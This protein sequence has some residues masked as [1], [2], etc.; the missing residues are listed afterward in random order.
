MELLS[1][2]VVLCGHQC[3]CAIKW[4]GVDVY[5]CADICMCV[6]NKQFELL[7]FVFESVYVDLHYDQ[8]SLTFPAGSV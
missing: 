7:W 3:T 8:I 4:S 1:V 2:L 5:M 6:E